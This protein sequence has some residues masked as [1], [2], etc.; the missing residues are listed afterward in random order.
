MFGACGVLGLGY[1]GALARW[2]E[3]ECGGGREFDG[4]EEAEDGDVGIDWAGGGV[5][6]VEGGGGAGGGGAVRRREPT[7]GERALKNLE[8]RRMRGERR[9]IWSWEE[10]SKASEGGRG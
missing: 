2:K 5:L 9:W 10:E 4:V 6:E 7:V 3:V 8:R 1:Q